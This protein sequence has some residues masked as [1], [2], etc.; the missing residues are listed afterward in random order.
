M[1]PEKKV[2][3]LQSRAINDSLEL[4]ELFPCSRERCQSIIAKNFPPKREAANRYTLLNKERGE[5]Q[6][7]GTRPSNLVLR[8]VSLN[9]LVNDGSTTLIASLFP[10]AIIAFGFSKFEV[11]VLVAVGYLVN[12]IFQ[13][14]T[15]RY[16]E[17]FESRN[18]L[19][20][21]I[22]II[23]V[24]MIM[25]ALSSTF[26]SMLVAILVLRF[27][28]SFFHPVGV[29][30]ISR[31][32]SGPWLDRSMGIQ[33]A[34]GNLGILLVFLISAP[35]YVLF[36]WQAPFLLYATLDVATVGVTLFFFSKAIAA[37]GGRLQAQEATHEGKNEEEEEKKEEKPRSDVEKDQG[38]KIG[39]RLGLP[40]FF[41]VSSFVSGGSFAVFSNYGNI[42]LF[43]AKFGVSTS[44][45]IMAAWVLSAFFGAILTG[46][47]TRRLSRN[48][49]LPLSFAL[50]SVSALTF[51]LLSKNP[52]AI[53]ASLLMNGFFLSITYPATYSELSAHLGLGSKRKGAAFGI[54]F[55]SQIAG[56]SIM[57]FL[58]GYIADTFSLHLA[59]ELVFGLLV[60]ASCFAYLWTK[61]NMKRSLKR[62]ETKVVD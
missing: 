28:S 45:F 21:G 59:F 49:I 43:D 12:M 53:V 37:V 11:G 2:Q 27:G 61:R 16:S 58:S 35:L 18:L 55:S 9:H 26:A 50:S 41:L 39:G 23:A 15:G 8:L 13:P 19:S 54:L 56:A 36:G 52:L 57:G 24:S 48:V 10:A 3:K 29:S 17:R 4:G 14:L 33:S 30:A 62:S 22:S 34:F 40:P 42:L 31:N 38:E 51:S 6:E 20:L 7:G 1:R 5:E 46:Y 60:F 25:F 44:N 47:L 32:Y